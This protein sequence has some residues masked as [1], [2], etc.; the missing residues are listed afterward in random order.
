VLDGYVATPRV[1]PAALG[2]EAGLFGALALA[3]RS[4]R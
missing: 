4:S 3:P 1:V 2:Q